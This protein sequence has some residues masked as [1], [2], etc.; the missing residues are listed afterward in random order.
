[1]KNLLITAPFVITVAAI[2]VGSEQGTYVNPNPRLFE[3]C[4]VQ[5]LVQLSACCNDVLNKLDDC[6]ASDLACECCALQSMKKECYG[7]CPGNPSNNFLTALFDD[8]ASLSDINACSLP[9]RKDDSVP[10][11]KNRYEKVEEGED[12]EPTVLKSKVSNN[13]EE[14]KEFQESKSENETIVKDFANDS[15]ISNTTTASLTPTLTNITDLY[16]TTKVAK[17][18]D[19]ESSAVSIG[20]KLSLVSILCIL[21]ASIHILT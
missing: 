6:K 12:E 7:L 15:S 4:D 9:F 20:F 18:A 14:R 11:E 13:G 10:M 2:I 1:M 17:K 21:A 5:D 8:C 16:N 19:S 3:N